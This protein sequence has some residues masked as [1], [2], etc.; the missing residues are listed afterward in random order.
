MMK[1]LSQFQ[2]IRLRPTKKKGMMAR[3]SVAIPSQ[4]I[5]R[6]GD[7][8]QTDEHASKWTHL[9]HLDFVVEHK[10]ILL[11]LL[12]ARKSGLGGVRRKYVHEEKVASK[13]MR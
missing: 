2:R 9:L 6:R 3:G 10:L 8:K 11:C 1:G 13:P 12:K 7:E 5:S 4:D